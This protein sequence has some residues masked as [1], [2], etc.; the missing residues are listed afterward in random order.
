MKAVFLDRSSFPDTIQFAYPEGITEI[1][2]YP[3]SK[4]E[5]VKKRIEGASIVLTNKVVLTKEVIERAHNLKLVQVTATGI[6]NVAAKAC[7]DKGIALQ[8]VDG[9]SSISVPEHTFAL[10]LALRR[11]LIAYINDVKSGKWANSEFFCCLDYPIKDLA[12]TTLA[13]VGKGVIG[14]KVADIAKVFGMKVIFVEHK[15]AETVRDGYVSFHAAIQQADVISLHCPLTDTT[16]DMIGEAEFNKMKSDAILLN[17]GRG[18]IVN[19]Q[20]LIKAL[21]DKT[22]MGAG[23]DVATQEPMPQD[24]PLQ[25]LTKL[26]NFLLTPHIAWGS[27][28]AMQTLANIAMDKINQFINTPS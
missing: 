27:N 9:Y 2:E 16:K 6:N 5:D 26:P 14:N 11:N 8:N 28:E 15:N 10:L 22:I 17:M 19:E 21:T 24:H 23:F 1:I 13:I 20:A 4:P 3:N 7:E 12:N 25:A 18:G